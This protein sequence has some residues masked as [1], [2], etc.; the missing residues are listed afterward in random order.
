MIDCD[1]VETAHTWGMAN[2]DGSDEMAVVRDV[3]SSDVSGPDEAYDKFV[4]SS[5]SDLPG[6]YY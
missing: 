3:D 1:R 5:V 4:I 2:D 6:G